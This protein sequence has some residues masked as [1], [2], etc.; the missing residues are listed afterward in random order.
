MTTESTATPDPQKSEEQALVSQEAA[1]ESV[2]AEP[3]QKTEEEKLWAEMIAVDEPKPASNRVA[4]EEVSNEFETVS[5]EPPETDK[6]QPSEGADKQQPSTVTDAAPV[7]KAPSKDD[8]WSKVPPEVRAAFEAEFGEIRKT[9]LNAKAEVTRVRKQYEDLK[10]ASASRG[11]DAEGSKKAVEEL[12]KS[13][14]ADFPEIAKPVKDAL[15]PIAKQLETLT[16]SEETRRAVLNEEVVQHIRSQQELLDAAHPGWEAEYVKGPK[17]KAFA[18]W[19]QDQPKRLR[20]I[21]FDTNHEHIFD[22]QGAIEVFDAFKSAIAAAENPTPA[23]PSGPTQE[24]SA[25]RASQFEG[26]KSPRSPGGPP[27]VSGIPKEG[28][29]QSIWDAFPDD[30]SDDRFRRRA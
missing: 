18:G 3:P 9:A 5:T 27:L 16:T 11:A 8:L 19:I 14:A 10:K 21:V 23:P 26:T 1:L 25:K 28:D 6:N 29:P 12:D 20:D 7:A 15:A 17:A 24:L 4:G 2:Q 13:L 22:A 30:N